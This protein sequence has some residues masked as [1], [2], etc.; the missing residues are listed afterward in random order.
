[1]PYITAP[2]WARRVSYGVLVGVYTMALVMGA[3]AVLL[4]PT[5][6][7]ARMPSWLTDAWGVLAVAGALG[8]LYGAVTRRY[9]WEWVWLIAL[10]GATVVYAITVWDIVGDAP[11]R[12]AQAGAI[13]TMALSLTLRYV[14]LWSIRS[15]E[16][17]DHKARTGRTR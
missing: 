8:C 11:T 1:M 3:G 9:R 15:R 2:P 12:L 4:T 6:I 5:T 13:S 7:S 14:Q 10:I 16:V 17:A